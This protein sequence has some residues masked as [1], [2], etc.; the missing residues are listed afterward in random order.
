MERQPSYALQLCVV[1]YNRTNIRANTPPIEGPP[2]IEV[3][4]VGELLPH[5]F[6]ENP[7]ALLI[8]DPPPPPPLQGKILVWETV[9]QA[10]TQIHFFYPPPR[11]QEF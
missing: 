1:D 8:L 3:L 7:T 6:P 10:I 11:V 9:P 4:P 2:H 5:E